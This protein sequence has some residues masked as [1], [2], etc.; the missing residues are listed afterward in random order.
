[1]LQS[2]FAGQHHGGSNSNPLGQIISGLTHSGGGHGHS[3]GG[4]ALGGVGGKLAGQLVSNLFS[5]DGDHKPQNYHSGQSTAQQQH[6]GGLAGSVM[7]GVAHMFGGQ[8]DS[9]SVVC[10]ERQKQKPRRLA[11]SNRLVSCAGPD[12]R[13]LEHGPH[14]RLHR[15]GPSSLV[16]AAIADILQLGGG[17]HAGV[18]GGG[19]PA[20]A[21]AVLP[22]AAP[23]HPPAAEPVIQRV[24]PHLLRTAPARPNTTTRAVVRSAPQPGPACAI[25]S[26]PLGCTAALR[27]VPVRPAV[28]R[29]SPTPRPAQLRGSPTA[30]RRRH[31]PILPAA[32]AARPAAIRRPTVVRQPGAP[33]P[34]RQSPGLPKPRLRRGTLLKCQ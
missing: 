16:P 25:L 3:G 1:M 4:G 29:R 32:A 9:G 10:R 20:D 17:H 6:S 34:P 14:R 31:A 12:L 11:K 8:H 28:L 33:Y 19:P 5:S 22:P 21:D 23:Q 27:T 24:L 7:G 18:V 15:H 13:L 2:Q 30:L 26:A